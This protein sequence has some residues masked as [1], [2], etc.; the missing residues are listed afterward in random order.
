GAAVIEFRGDR[1]SAAEP[2]YQRPNMCKTYA[3][4]RLVLDAGAAE[5]VE[6]ALMVLGVD[7]AAIVDHVEDGEA[8]LGAAADFDVARHARLQ[9]FQRIVDQVREN[10]LQREAVAD[11]IGYRAYADLCLGFGG[12]MRHGFTDPLDEITHPDALGGERP[13]AF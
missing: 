5:Q 6:D 11:D 12:L 7:A 8:E 13:P 4:A 9:I 3:L 1:H 2:P 10:L